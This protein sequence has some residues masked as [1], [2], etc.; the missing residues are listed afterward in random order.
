MPRSLPGTPLRVVPLLDSFRWREVALW[1]EEPG[2][3]VVAEALGTAAPF[4]VGA[5]PVGIHPVLRVLPF[6]Q[7]LR[8]FTPKH[9]LVGHGPPLHGPGIGAATDRAIKHARRD[10]PRL[11]L[12][13]PK[14]LLG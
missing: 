7:A 13:L 10:A 14:L 2:V 8:G 12:T 1:W 3:L 6:P 4:T 5:G 11:L 9:L